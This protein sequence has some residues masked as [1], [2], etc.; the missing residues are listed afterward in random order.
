MNHKLNKHKHSR[1]IQSPI[2]MQQSK[3]Q[4][5]KKVWSALSHCANNSTCENPDIQP[6]ITII[7]ACCSS[8]CKGFSPFLILFSFFFFSFNIN[9]FIY[10]GCCYCFMYTFMFMS[11][12]MWSI[13]ILI[14]VITLSN[15]YRL[16]ACNLPLAACMGTAPPKELYTLS[17]SV[18]VTFYLISIPERES[19]RAHTHCCGCQC[20]RTDTFWLLLFW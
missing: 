10:C 18:L 13:L 8:M 20:R 3:K 15:R 9:I 12:N 7:Y 1:I 6:V 16:S 2:Q 11:I 14:S 17:K 5:E 4:N 19:A